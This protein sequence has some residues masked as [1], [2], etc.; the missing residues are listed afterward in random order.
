MV[1]IGLETEKAGRG[2]HLLDEMI[3]EGLA[4]IQS[5][6]NPR[7]LMERLQPYL[8]KN[9]AGRLKEQQADVAGNRSGRASSR[10]RSR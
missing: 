5:G 2:G 3:L 10:A 6:E 8:P 1:A 7:I 4:S 9:E